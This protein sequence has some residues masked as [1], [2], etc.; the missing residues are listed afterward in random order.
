MDG[1]WVGIEEIHIVRH[2]D[3]RREFFIQ[4]DAL[5]YGIGAVLFQK[6]EDG[7]GNPIVFYS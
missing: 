7:G 1:V 4:C 6:V 5:K 2:P 3:L